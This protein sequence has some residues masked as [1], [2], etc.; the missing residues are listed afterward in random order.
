[1]SNENRVELVIRAKDLAK[2]S[3]AD[4]ADV[5]DRLQSELDS[6]D[7]AG[8]PAS[9]SVAELKQQLTDLKTVSDE[10]TKR[11]S[12]AESFTAQ[13]A[14]VAKLSDQL[15]KAKA[16]VLAHKEAMGATAKASK[17]Q[18][19]SLKALE[20]VVRTSQRQYQSALGVQDRLTRQLSDLGLS[21]TTAAG[22][23]Q[24]LSRAEAKLDAQAQKAEAN[25]RS[26]DRLLREVAATT[27]VNAA[28]DREQEQRLKTTASLQETVAAGAERL[29]RA[30]ERAAAV[31]ADTTRVDRFSDNRL[32]P[33]VLQTAERAERAYAAAVRATEAAIAARNA[34]LAR[35]KFRAVADEATKAS[36]AARALAR[37]LKLPEPTT[38]AKAI[39]AIVN[40]AKAAAA[41]LTTISAALDRIDAL[42][43]AEQF[44]AVKVS[45]STLD[46]ALKK[47]GQAAKSL[48][49]LTSQKD[50]LRDANAQYAQAERRLQDLAAQVRASNAP[51]AELLATFRQ[52]QTTVAATASAV[53]Q[54]SQRYRETRT[55]L[56]QFGVST[57]DVVAAQ[58]QLAAT[59]QRIGAV[60]RD[61][62][63]TTALRAAAE[64]ELAAQIRAN[65]PLQDAMAAGE[66]KLSAARKEAAAAGA[67]LSRVD[68]FRGDTLRPEVLRTAER[69]ERAYAAAVGA[70]AAALAARKAALAR[71]EFR[72]TANNAN[73]AAEAARSLARALQLPEPRVNSAAIAAIIQPAKE[74]SASLAG[75]ATV[76]ERVNAVPIKAQT[77][78]QFDALRDSAA[79]LADALKR[80][81]Q[82]AKG[83][84][85]LNAQQA[86]VQQAGQAYA[87]ARAK[88]RDLAQQVASASAPSAELQRAFEQQQAAVK[89]AAGVL[90]EA[91]S[92]FRATRA[93]LRAF[94]VDTRSAAAAGKQ[95]QASATEIVAAQKK[96][97][98][99]T[100]STTKAFKLWGEGGRTT[101]SWAQRMRGEFL[102]LTASVV[103]L[104]SALRVGQG[105]ID[106]ASGREQVIKQLVL[107]TGNAADAK[108]KYAELGKTADE[109]G[110]NFEKSA[111][112]YTDIAFA[113]RE[114]GVS[115]EEVDRFY[116]NLLLTTRDLSL[117]GQQ[118]ER[119][120][121][122]VS[123]IFSKNKLSSEELGQQLGESLKGIL[124][125]SAQAAGIAAKDFQ[126][127]LE[128]GQFTGDAIIGIIDKYREKLGGLGT[129]QDGYV[130][131][132]ARFENALQRIKLQLADTGFLD[133]VTKA[134]NTLT[135]AADN[136]D[137]RDGVRALGAAFTF[138]A[139]AVVWAATHLDTLRNI[140]GALML[141][142]VAGWVMGLTTAMA[143][144][145]S[146]TALTT[147]AVTSLTGAFGF[148]LS[149]TPV[150]WA[151]GAAAALGALYVAFESVRESVILVVGGFVEL[152][153]L[154]NSS[155]TDFG[156]N[157]QAALARLDEQWKRT[158]KAWS[159][160][161]PAPAA[162]AVP[163][164]KASEAAWKEKAAADADGAKLAGQAQAGALKKI[165]DELEKGLKSADQKIA[166]KRGDLL[167]AAKAQYKELQDEIDTLAKRDSKAAAERQA[168]LNKLIA[169]TAKA[170]APK[171]T[172]ADRLKVSN[173]AAIEG[174][175][176]DIE[177]GKSAIESGMKEL[178][179]AFE[180]H[181]TSIAD[182]YTG[183][184]DY[185]AA[186]ARVEVSGFDRQ[187]AILKSSKTLT[188]EA[189]KEIVDLEGKK[190]QALKRSTEAQIENNRAAAQAIKAVREQF[191]AAQ[192]NLDRAR[193]DELTP[194]LLEARNT[195]VQLLESATKLTGE[196]RARAE[197]I[198]RQ[199]YDLQV[200]T[201]QMAELQRQQEHLANLSQAAVEASRLGPLS[202]AA[203]QQ[204][205]NRERLSQ[206]ELLAERY[207]T[208]GDTGSAAYRSIQVEIVKLGAQTDLVIDQLANMAGAATTDLI[209]E[210]ARKG[211]SVSDWF[212][213]FGKSLA[214]S[215]S[216]A[217]ADEASATMAA[218]VRAMLKNMA[219][220]GGGIWQ[221]LFGAALGGAAGGGAETTVYGQAHAG[222]LVGFGGSGQRRGLTFNPAAMSAAVA[223]APRYHTGAAGLGLRSDEVMT[224]LKKREEVLA[225]E[226]PRNILNGGAAAMPGAPA[227]VSQPQIKI[228]NTIDPTDVVSQGLSTAAG[229]KAFINTMAS[230]R[231]TVRKLLG[232]K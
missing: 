140:V 123:Q 122:A 100:H 34:E 125:I 215:L 139:D 150:G 173:A 126:K 47:V 207:R 86:A 190:E 187:I 217:F 53:Q 157:A 147:G 168:K 145:G 13:G 119:V 183:R 121:Y 165:D 209:N 78:A 135:Q 48:D 164:A 63:T 219:S 50:A 109:I 232:V 60:Q 89:R 170:N 107:I 174:I 22:D 191:Q 82:A 45:A 73:V 115:A 75:V 178:D 155:P 93:E 204:E 132:Q 186:T 162:S 59:A 81:E 156:K 18:K 227:P 200:Q 61:A 197:A 189:A 192:N 67:D 154:L 96:I 181:L 51:N 52:Q 159:S 176:N 223:A 228:I 32:R 226:D 6:V 11:R 70:T 20:D 113:A 54:A 198:A 17:D 1:M 31:G 114:A 29:A 182:Y 44:T 221:T 80:V 57:N 88:L 39:E 68:A 41:S 128:D 79:P 92:Q 3:I 120:F 161:V 205:I 116:K 169:S 72:A 105:A 146:V 55:A 195:Y 90:G 65:Q 71:D 94:G 149:L 199:T 58:Q 184:S 103:G 43:V 104:Y 84:D 33:E 130:Q 5:I 214:Q 230:N 8:G 7:K 167:G 136:G 158:K 151:L 148:L 62:A 133:S 25:L 131:A 138:L 26:R 56:Q 134:L 12:L 87:D 222:A 175:K 137:F 23:I 166:E 194:D 193:G 21:A 225:A 99:G 129:Q 211:S 38:N 95:L 142:K 101:L 144:A 212:L 66:R 37:S 111:K 40:P 141:Y 14:A 171:G 213:A 69:A 74:A 16:A 160:D 203:A 10:I 216:K 83:L 180:D 19:D 127:A 118:T 106:A 117:S 152:F 206:L 229:E 124:G 24:T 110:V 210:M 220:E 108:T 188:A 15:E 46:E 153:G 218:A 196:E 9:R 112:G 231:E 77:K 4:L 64:R 201:A 30:R 76:L 172:G 36:E 143:A 202:Q 91:A 28:F 98:D 35:D 208:M 102:S 179:R 2:K 42:P 85:A 27:K 185:A 177:A 163:G 49:A 97:A 224:V